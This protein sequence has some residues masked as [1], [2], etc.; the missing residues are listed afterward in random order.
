MKMLG[1]AK[2]YAAGGVLAGVMMV[3]FFTV[4]YAADVM[5]DAFNGVTQSITVNSSSP[6]ASNATVDGASLGGERDFEATWVSGSDVTLASNSGAPANGALT[7]SSATG[8]QGRGTVTFD[9][10]D[11]APTTLDPDG[12]CPVTCPDLTDSGANTHMRVRVVE[13]DLASTLHFRIYNGTTNNAADYIEYALS[14]PGGIT[15]GE[16]VDFLMPYTGFSTFGAG[17]NANDAGAVQIFFNQGAPTTALDV[18]IDFFDSTDAGLDLGDL[19]NSYAMTTIAQNGARHQLTTGLRLGGDRDGE[20]DGVPSVNADGDDAASLS[21]EAGVTRST[22]L[23]PWNNANGG[24]VEVVIQGCSGF[25][26]LNGWI[27][28]NDDGDFADTDEV[29]ISNALRGNGTHLEAFSIP[30]APFPGTNQDVYA[31]FRVCQSGQTCNTVTG[32]VAT[33][34]VEDYFWTFTPTAVTLQD[35]AVSSSSTLAVTLLVGV[36]LLVALSGAVLWVRRRAA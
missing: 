15:P 31:R 22:I 20:A 4:A 7:F 29:V 35:M 5:I 19:P 16:A 2:K 34:E 6:T 33:G 21:D 30:A 25:C 26:R 12:L 1:Q 8:T 11:G 3:L 24:A 18:A 27:D 9:G 17:A 14:L 36:L 13:N 32:S 10:T 28:W 23:G